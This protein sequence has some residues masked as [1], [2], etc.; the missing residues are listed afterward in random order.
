MNKLRHLW[1]I[2]IPL[3]L[4]G[5][6]IYAIWPRPFETYISR[7]LDKIG[8]RI[9]LQIPSG[10]KSEIVLSGPNESLTFTFFPPDR[11]GWWPAFLR[12]WFP[13]LSHHSN[14][15]NIIVARQ[16]D[17]EAIGGAITEPGGRLQIGSQLINF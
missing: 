6:L 2:G 7:P 16:D 12:R 4:A 1:K 3:V 14:S 9:Q 8:T 5:W 11:P 15:L 17:A 10:W 13:P